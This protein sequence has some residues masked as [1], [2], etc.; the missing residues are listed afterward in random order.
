VN[1]R[2][3]QLVASRFTYIWEFRVTASGRADF[4]FE[5]GPSGAWVSLFR[6]APGYI[7]TLLLRD[8]ADPLR[9]VTVDR[10]ESKEVHGAFRSKNLAEYEEIDQRCQKYTTNECLLGEFSEGT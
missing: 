3:G 5:Y 6:K 7:E 9:Y 10:W 1:D 2:K 8:N 4:E